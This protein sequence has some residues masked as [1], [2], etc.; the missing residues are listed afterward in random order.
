[1]PSEYWR[2]VPIIEGIV[3]GSGHEELAVNIR[4]EG[5]IECLPEDI[6]V[7][8]PATVDANGI[9]GIKLAMPKGFEALLR[10]RTGVL[11][12]TAEAA[13]LGSK[14]FALQALLAEPVVNS[15]KKAEQLLDMM[16]DYQKEYL[17]YLK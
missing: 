8:V 5:F 14:E 15:L 4:N 10:N 13:L 1:L 9:H 11:E 16:L 17:G 2:V 6:Y 12:L 3:T 7:E